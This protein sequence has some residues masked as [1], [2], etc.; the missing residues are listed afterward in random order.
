MPILTGGRL[1]GNSG[2]YTMGL[3]NVQIGATSYAKGESIVEV[4]RANYTVAR[5]KRNVLNSSSVGILA[6]NRQGQVADNS[7]NRGLCIDGVFTL[8]H[9]VRVISM[10]AK[11]FSPGVGSRDMA[12]VL[13]IDWTGVLFGLNARYTDIQEDFNAEMGFIPRLDI[14]S[15]SL[16]ASW[17]PRP[18]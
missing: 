13:N 11:T 17:T 8:P 7:Y 14:R 2:A 18:D 3:L 4:P 5:L 9:N 10:L 6:L 15:S 12:G 16:G 1:T